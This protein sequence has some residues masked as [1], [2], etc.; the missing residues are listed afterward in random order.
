MMAAKKSG[1]LPILKS[2]SGI[3][4]T[5]YV[6]NAGDRTATEKK[7]KNL[8]EN[9][10]ESLQPVMEPDR[11]SKF[12]API[13]AL[14]KN[15][16]GL[17]AVRGNIGIFRNES[18]LRVICVPIAVKDVCIVA[19]SFHVKPLLQWVQT[20]C[21]FHFLAFDKAEAHL[22][23]GDSGSFMQIS[24]FQFANSSQ[25]DNGTRLL[26]W[27]RKHRGSAAPDLFVMSLPDMIEQ[28][29][30]LESRRDLFS[31]VAL[32]FDRSFDRE[33]LTKT[34]AEIRSIFAQRAKGYLQAN[35]IEFSVAEDE[36]R[37]AKNIFQISKAVARGE[38]RKLMIASGT[39]VFGKIDDKSGSLAIHPYDLDH[40]DDDILDDLAQAVIA[41]GGEVIVA[42]DDQMPQHRIAMAILKRGPT[43]RMDQ[44][45]DQIFDQT[46]LT[47]GRVL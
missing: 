6:S 43:V 37:I 42:D 21:D 11:L 15:V 35:L 24:S 32:S 36:S 12:L 27:L 19:T 16:S 44:E 41:Q 38:V 10:Y 34:C 47:F 8:I 28:Q 29:I 40:E 17:G 45:R 13:E 3:H 7:L 22:F 9:V 26:H 4:V 14:A 20:E 33:S 31:D 30:S 1:L 18:Y 5:G 25:A 2:K 46:D 39:R 23:K